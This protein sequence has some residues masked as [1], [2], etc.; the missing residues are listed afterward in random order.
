[1]TKLCHVLLRFVTFWSSAD[2]GR[3]FLNIPVELWLDSAQKKKWK[4]NGN[5]QIFFWKSSIFSIFQEKSKIYLNFKKNLVIFGFFHFFLRRIQQIKPEN[6]QIFFWCESKKK[7][8]ND[9]IRTLVHNYYNYFPTYSDIQ[10]HMIVHCTPLTI[11]YKLSD[12]YDA[13][14]TL[15]WLITQ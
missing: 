6:R 12:P 8:V 14:M 13:Y 9:N 7:K 2:L 3:W 10:C 11:L 15:C 5:G 4:K 1:M